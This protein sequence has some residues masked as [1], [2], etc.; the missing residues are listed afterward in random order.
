MI[1]KRKLLHGF[2]LFLAFVGL[3]IGIHNTSG[4]EVIIEILGMIG[5]MYLFVDV[6]GV[7]NKK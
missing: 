1:D 5:V 2:C 7:R 4:W 6:L 3:G